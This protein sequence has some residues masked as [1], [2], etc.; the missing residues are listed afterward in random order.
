MSERLQATPIIFVYLSYPKSK[1]SIASF[2]EKMLKDLTLT[3]RG[4]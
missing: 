3:K 2:I 4:E 1:P